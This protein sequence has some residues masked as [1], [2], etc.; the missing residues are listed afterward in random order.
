MLPSSLRWGETMPQP[1]T[2][3]PDAHPAYRDTVE[4]YRLA[5]LAWKYLQSRD[6]PRLG[7]TERKYCDQYI[8]ANF[9]PLTWASGDTAGQDWTQAHQ[10][11]AFEGAHRA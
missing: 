9:H 2:P 6:F 10:D 3:R 7:L 5:L 11:A 8:K 1:E 4:R